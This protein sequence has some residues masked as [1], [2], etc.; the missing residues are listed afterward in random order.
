LYVKDMMRRRPAFGTLVALLVLASSLPMTA[1]AQSQSTGYDSPG[2][3][4]DQGR[5]ELTWSFEP[6]M[7]GEAWQ[8]TMWDAIGIGLQRNYG[9]VI[10][11]YK[12][13]EAEF[14]VFGGKGIYD[15]GLTTDFSGFNETS[16][17]ASNLDGA[18]VQEQK[19]ARLDF[20]LQQLTPIGGTVE[21][22]FDNRRFESN[23]QFAAVNPSFRVDFD[24]S[25]QQP[26]LRDMGKLATERNLIIA[27][28]DLGVSLE[29]FEQ[30]VIEVVRTVGNAYWTL[31][32]AR[33]QLA[34]AEEALRLA[35]EL[36]EQNKVKVDVGTLAPLEL[37]QSEAGMATRRDELIRAQIDVGN[38]EDDLR[39]AMNIPEGNLWTTEIVPQSSPDITRIEIDVNDSVAQALENRPEVRTKRIQNENL[40]VDLD[41]R[42]NQKMPRL[43][44]A[45]TYGY[46]GLGGDV[47]LRDFITGEI[48][49]ERPGDYSDAID[50]IKERTFDGWSWA[51]NLVVPIQ[52]RDAKAQY[53]IADVAVQRGQAELEQLELQVSTEVR[54]AARAVTTA[55]ALVDSTR[56][57]RRLEE[58]NLKAEQK[59][60]ENGMSTSFQVLQI[61]EDLATARSNAVR[62]ETG[63]RKAL[64]EFYRATGTL[65]DEIGVEIAGQEEDVAATEQEAK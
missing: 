36:H 57:S 8:L 9:L 24:L 49:L 28:N 12:L 41:Y 46:N 52:N 65:A 17:A 11:R 43:D 30:Q 47:T 15:L 64:I 27:R 1:F 58:E 62:A 23:S 31:I 38:A 22:G 56:V 59:R 25:Y 18:L 7:S 14:R 13:E 60:Y 63:Y 37:I 33:A 35:T 54:K 6:T 53:T 40:L 19:Q 44:F 21:L 50:Q 10:E 20:G 16:P 29:T 51:L 32:E 55:E 34:V 61:Q 4:V 2:Y 48:I 3:S 42:R 39:Q 26:L 5:G 45:G